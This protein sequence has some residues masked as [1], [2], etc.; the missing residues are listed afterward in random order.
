MSTAPACGSS[1]CT[2]TLTCADQPTDDASGPDQGLGDHSLPDTRANDSPAAPEAGK[3]VITPLDSGCDVGAVENCTNGIDDNCNNLVDCAD[4]MCM[5]Q[6]FACVPAAPSGW[7]G[8]GAYYSGASAAPSCPGGYPTDSLDGNSDVVG[9]PA[10][11]SCSCGAVQGAGCSSVGLTYYQQLNCGGGSCGTDSLPPSFCV[12]APCDAKSVAASPPTVQG[13]ACTP[14]ANDTIPPVT[15]SKSQRGCTGQVGG[16]CG[17]AMVCAPPVASPFAPTRCVYSPGTQPCPAGYANP[18]TT[19]YGGVNDTRGCT[20]CSCGGA[21]GL[22]CSQPTVTLW[23]DSVCSQQQLST[24]PA[25]GS[26]AQLGGGGNMIPKGGEASAFGLQGVGSC[27]AGGGAPQG[28]VTPA[29]P[30]TVCCL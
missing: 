12:V 22:S 27:P 7:T 25:D 6:G 29:K 11:C 8:P 5:S 15:W 24:I 16:G 30:T 28:S 3:D 10:M 17:A 21:A 1:D 18:S 13:G 23:T 20:A 2:E 9:S 26:C 14:S 19:A 4:P